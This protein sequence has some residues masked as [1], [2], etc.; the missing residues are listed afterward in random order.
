MKTLTVGML[1]LALAGATWAAPQGDTAKTGQTD[2]TA[3]QSTHKTSHK[4]HV[5]KHQQ[6]KSDVS[7]AK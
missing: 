3:K 6:P 1:A 2:Q 4:K 5:R 7:P